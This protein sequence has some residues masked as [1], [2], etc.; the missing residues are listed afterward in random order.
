MRTSATAV[1][2]ARVEPLRREA[3]ARAPA[4]RQPAP[5]R[6]G[7]QEEEA[8]SAGRPRRRRATG[9]PASP[10]RCPKAGGDGQG[11]GDP[12]GQLRARTAIGPRRSARR[13]T[14]SSTPARRRDTPAW[15]VASTGR[16]CARSS[17]RTATSWRR[18]RGAA[19]LS[20]DPDASVAVADARLG[21]PVPDPQ[22]ILCVGLN[23]RAHASEARST[24]R[25]SRWCSRSSPT[26]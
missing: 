25:P 2:L 19:V 23:Y 26:S 11:T 10:R 22:K 21:P 9:P 24:S 16:A 20:T 13:A 3:R 6:Q 7:G 14:G 8:P 12:P 15:T 17:P 5:A 18:S 4:D 1:P